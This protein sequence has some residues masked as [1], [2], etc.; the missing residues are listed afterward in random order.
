[1][2]WTKVAR[3]RSD[4]FVFHHVG[5]NTMFFASV[6][7]APAENRATLVVTNQGD[8]FAAVDAMHRRMIETFFR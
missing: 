1:M 6:W 7:A 4:G 5:S 3:G 2:G 8:A